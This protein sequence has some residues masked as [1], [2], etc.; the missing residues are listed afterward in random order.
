MSEPIAAETLRTALAALTTEDWA[1]LREQG[2]PPPPVEQADSP[3]HSYAAGDGVLYDNDSHQSAGTVREVDEAGAIHVDLDD[4]IG[5]LNPGAAMVT[6]W[7][8]LRPLV[9]TP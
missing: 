4:Q 1:W 2:Y 7:R 5:H 9:G 6:S 3:D 8:Y